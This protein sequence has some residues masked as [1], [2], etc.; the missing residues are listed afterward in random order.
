ML[1][2]QGVH[3]LVHARRAQRHQPGGGSALAIREEKN[4]SDSKLEKARNQPRREEIGADECK[5]MK[6]N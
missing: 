5:K 6:Q 1:E 2:P 3:C 4:S